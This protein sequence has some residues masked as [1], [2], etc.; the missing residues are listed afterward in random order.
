M[1]PAAI[2]QGDALDQVLLGADDPIEGILVQ[3][4]L[5]CQLVH[6]PSPDATAEQELDCFFQN[7]LLTLFIVE[8]HQGSP[9]Y[10]I[11]DQLV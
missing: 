5:G 2:V 7:P 6:V 9:L 4:C 11:L 3:T 8:L 1:P 10:T